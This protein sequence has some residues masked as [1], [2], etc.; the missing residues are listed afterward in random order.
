[1]KKI[2]RFLLILA[3]GVLPLRA[4]GQETDS[5]RVNLVT[6]YPGAEVFQLYGH[7]ELRVIDAEGDWYYNYGLFDFQ[8]RNFAGRFIAGETDYMC[9]A[10]PPSFAIG[11]YQG[12][13]KIV[14][15]ELNLTQAQATQIAEY[16]RNNAKPEN[17][18]YRYKFFT[19]NCATRPRNIIE[20]ALGGELKY[21]EGETST[22]RKMVSHYS[23]NYKWNE[24]GVDLALGT[25]ADTLINLRE[26]MFVP[27]ILMDGM[28]GATVKREGRVEPVVKNTVVVVDG[29]DE[30]DVLPP[31]SWLMSP[32]TV[33][34]L[35]LIVSALFCLRAMRRGKAVRWFA[36]LLFLVAG[37]A[38]M[39]VFYLTFFSIHEA[40]SPNVNVLWLNPLYLMLAVLVWFKGR[41][42][43]WFSMALFALAALALVL[44]II[45]VQH[46]NIAF[47]PMILALLLQLWV[48]IKF[49]KRRL[50]R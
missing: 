24:F 19:N 39:V 5:V 21:P 6:I 31:T 36:T 38:G 42:V 15:Q 47:Y 49:S 2:L 28:A 30:G 35:L 43:Q 20:D 29:T 14:E 18:V 3:V 34:V 48:V 13:R 8:A 4:L 16:L 10:V 26:Q 7:T 22:Y 40:T 1:M 45:G 9:G 23:G 17:A 32:L 12:R 50:D 46:A 27:M 41:V 25:P 37:I 44:F 11:E 33:G